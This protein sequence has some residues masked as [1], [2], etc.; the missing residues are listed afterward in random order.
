MEYISPTKYA[1]V[2]NV[3]RDLYMNEETAEEAAPKIKQNKPKKVSEARAKI[4]AIK[5]GLSPDKQEQLESYI[6][7]IEEIKKEI[8]KLIKQGEQQVEETGGNMMN[9]HLKV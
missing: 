9:L 4:E 2:L 8:K 3:F 1:S 7:S 5:K 6:S